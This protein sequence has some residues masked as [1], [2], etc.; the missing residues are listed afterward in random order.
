MRNVQRYRLIISDIIDASG[1]EVR[2][3]TDDEDEVY[4]CCPFCVE[5][6]ES[7][8]NRFRL[9]LNMRTGAAHCFNCHWK[10]RGVMFTARALCK[11]LNVGINLRGFVRQEREA[12]LKKESE[13]KKKRVLPPA[14]GLPEEYQAFSEEVGKAGRRARRYLQQ[15]QVSTLQI[16]KHRIGYA[17]DGRLANRLIFPVVDPDG[18]VHGCVG[19]DFTGE[20]SPKYLNTPGMKLLWNAHRLATTAVVVEGIFDALRVEMAL[21]RTRDMLAVSRLGSAITPFQLDQLKLYEKVIVLPDWDRAGVQG[22]IELC[23]RCDA[24]GIHVSVCVPKS[25]TGED[26]G[27]M[28]EDDII[29]RIKDTVPWTA[30]AEHRLLAAAAKDRGLGSDDE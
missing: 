22:A 28:T 8:D 10:A 23:G 17:S 29:D 25:M 6:G 3:R 15:R 7:T 26:P 24:R 20:Q 30:S 4:L 16:V 27:S 19:R 21:M 14:A 11:A 12:R 5:R 18:D 13:V 9:G 1:L 2:P